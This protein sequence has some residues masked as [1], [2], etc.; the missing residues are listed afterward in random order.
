MKTPSEIF[1]FLINHFSYMQYLFLTETNTTYFYQ[2][3]V[4]LIVPLSYLLLLLFGK[5]YTCISMSSKQTLPASRT[6]WTAFL[7]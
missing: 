6:S 5:F 2:N 7:L 3:T 4:N 1:K